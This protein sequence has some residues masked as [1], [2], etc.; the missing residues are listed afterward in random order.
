VLPAVV[1]GACLLLLV[2]QGPGG[3]DSRRK[4]SV[5]SDQTGS[6]TAGYLSLSPIPPVKWLYLV[7]QLYTKL[8]KCN[9]FKQ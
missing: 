4:Y 9:C 8:S 6:E 2:P 5:F 3:L 7:T 1:L